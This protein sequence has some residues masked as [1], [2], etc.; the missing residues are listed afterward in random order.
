MC[1]S[2]WSALSALSL[3]GC[4]QAGTKPAVD[5][6]AEERT[7]R[8]L[9]DSLA[10]AEARRDTVAILDAYATDAILQ[11]PGAPSLRGRQEWSPVF[12][13]FMKLPFNGQEM[14]DRT[15]VVAA[16]GDLAYDV[17]AD[18]LITKTPSGETVE[19]GK[20]IIIYRKI[21]GR[22]KI[23]ANSYSTDAAAGTPLPAPASK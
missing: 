2:R 4:S 12:Q 7:I 22:W 19:A 5:V 1:I 8:A 10:A 11:V 23:V 16:S 13:E 6:A 20:S 18:N 9:T 15:V 14:K 17:G 21:D 3:A